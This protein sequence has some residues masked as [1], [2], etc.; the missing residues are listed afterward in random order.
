MQRGTISALRMNLYQCD[1]HSPSEILKPHVPTNYTQCA[2]IPQSLG[3]QV[4][5]MYNFKNK[6]ARKAWEAS[7]PE[8][9]SNWL[10]RKLITVA[11]V[12]G[13]HIRNYNGFIVL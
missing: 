4:W 6:K 11:L 13:W 5:V 2:W 8:Q 7:L 1:P 9:I 10:D 12:Y 3:D